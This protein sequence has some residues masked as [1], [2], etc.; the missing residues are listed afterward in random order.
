[1][2]TSNEY[3]QIHIPSPVSQQMH[4]SQIHSA[5]DSSS[6]LNNAVGSKRDRASIE[7]EA[8]MNGAVGG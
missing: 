8:S 4:T 7:Q 3:R 6:V 1:M 2:I 5:L